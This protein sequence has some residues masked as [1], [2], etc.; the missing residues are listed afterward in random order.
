M[1]AVASV[2]ASDI[3]LFT[4][5]ALAEPY[6]LYDELRALGAVVELTRFDAYAVTRYA[7]ACEVLRDVATYTSTK[8]I[9]LNAERNARG[10]VSSITTDPPLHAQLRRTFMQPF[11][12]TPLRAISGRL[13]DEAE[14]VIARLAHVEEFDGVRQ[15]AHHLPL[16][17]VSAMVG[18][19]EEG[20]ENMLHWASSSFDAGGPLG[21]PRTDASDPIE[22][23]MRAWIE[24]NAR[25]PHLTPGGWAQ[26]LFDAEEAG[27]IPVGWASKLARDY[28]TPSLDTTIN[29][30][31]SLLWLL[32]QHPE[33]WDL[34]K[35]SPELIPGAIDEA[36]RL[37]SPIPW[38]TRCATVDTE[39]SGVRIPEGQRVMI[40]FA[41]GNR[42][43]LYW[44][45][46]AEFDVTRAN[47]ADHL[48]FGKGEH[49][50]AGQ[51]LAKLEIT[52]LL[53][54]MVRHVDRIEMTAEPVRRLNN[55]LRGLAEL[56][57][58]FVPVG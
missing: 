22:A 42:D 25:P 8:G 53:E 37:E 45:R 33:Q 1:T 14:N 15:L 38:F 4:D 26:A 51:G 13:K 27:K 55:S 50:C 34:I 2:P 47:A 24:A 18:I 31:S 29:A 17:V 19:P 10:T 21:Y 36:I 7:E 52:A 30:T 9:R 5:T 54:A 49:S 35:R 6:P 41:S 20:R 40:L 32:A 11:R 12:A 58:R 57:L 46:P 39:L 16:T 28:I 43:P 44:E 56:P 3:D 23:E 48:A